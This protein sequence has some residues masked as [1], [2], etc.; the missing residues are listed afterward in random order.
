M[1]VL[2]VVKHMQTVELDNL[3]QLPGFDQHIK[4]RDSKFDGHKRYS[5]VVTK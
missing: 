1:F 4:F 3:Q 2:I 5:Y